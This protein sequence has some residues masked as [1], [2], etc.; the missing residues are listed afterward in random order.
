MDA[1][2]VDGFQEYE[3]YSLLYAVSPDNVMLLSRAGFKDVVVV[4][5]RNS[6]DN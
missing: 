5:G 4:V 2:T 3:A 1:P 6:G